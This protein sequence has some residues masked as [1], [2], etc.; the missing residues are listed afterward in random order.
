MRR[1]FG[2]DCNP[3][4]RRSDVAESVVRL[5]GAILV[6][7][8]GL[9]ALALS[10]ATAPGSAAPGSGSAAET[11][12]VQVIVDETR[13]PPPMPLAG[14]YGM[15]RVPAHWEEPGGREVHRKVWVVPPVEKGDA[16]TIE[17]TPD[18]RQALPDPV[19]LDWSPDA[20]GWL[21]TAALSALWA[22][23]LGLT[24]L[25]L[26]P[27]RRRYWSRQWAAYS[28]TRSPHAQP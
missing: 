12:T 8:T 19:D 11:R 10:V 28:A 26:V 1:W 17:V 24:R 21:L 9:G 3:L 20:T 14:C 7:T 13:I 22:T 23:S 6:I 4:R 16:V 18:G 5:V 27:I 2:L 15:V 25:V